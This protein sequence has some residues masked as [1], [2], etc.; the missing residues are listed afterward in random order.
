MIGGA[1]SPLVQ[2]KGERNRK[3]TSHRSANMEDG[4]SLTIELADLK[5]KEENKSAEL[6]VPPARFLPTSR[7]IFLL[8]ATWAVAVFILLVILVATNIS[9]SSNSEDTLGADAVAS[10]VRYIQLLR[11]Q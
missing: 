10:H 11:K 2:P 4:G 3:S 1:S 5:V 6:S 9:L 7:T 8:R